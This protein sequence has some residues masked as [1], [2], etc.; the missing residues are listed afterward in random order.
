MSDNSSPLFSIIVPVYNVEKF[1]HKTL[2]SV[3]EQNFNSYE[4]IVVNDGSKDKS[5]EICYSFAQQHSQI[6]F[7]QTANG[8]LSAARNIGLKVAKGQYIIFLDGDDYWEGDNVLNEIADLIKMKNEPDVILH[9]F[10]IINLNNPSLPPYPI[11]FDLSDLSGDYY[12]DFPLLISRS[13]Y[14]S[15][16]W[17]KITKREIIIQNNLFFPVGKRHEDS[18]WTFKL[19]KHIHQYAIY[20]ST[21]YSY[22]EGRPGA[23]TASIPTQNVKDF[24]SIILVELEELADI[25]QRYP[26]L[27]EGLLSYIQREIY[28]V[29]R[30]FI[31]LADEDKQNLIG[32]LI[33]CCNLRDSYM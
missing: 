2:S 27:F 4:L 33:K 1:V 31:S 5:G 24:L 22:Y 30:F 3:L 9:S 6:T 28:F 11:N 15:S 10:K 26:E 13:I 17:T 21:F 32:D 19:A 16:A 20:D 29:T 14:R 23:I 8:G 18:E 25:K 12:T 7:I